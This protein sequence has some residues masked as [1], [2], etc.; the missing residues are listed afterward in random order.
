MHLQ[1]FHKLAFHADETIS[2]NWQVRI[3]QDEECTDVYLIGSNPERQAELQATGVRV[4]QV[5][6]VEDLP[7]DVF[8]W[9][10]YKGFWAAVNI[11]DGSLRDIGYCEDSVGATRILLNRFA[12]DYRKLFCVKPVK[13]EPLE[14]Y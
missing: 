9:Y 4:H 3:T 11:E 6:A 1:R 7:A 2:L 14:G 8:R 12:P 5:K 10:R 13:V